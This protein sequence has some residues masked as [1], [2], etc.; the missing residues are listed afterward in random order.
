MQSTDA[1]CTK[2]GQRELLKAPCDGKSDT[3]C[4]SMWSVWSEW[5]TVQ[6][7]SVTPRAVFGAAAACPPLGPDDIDVSRFNV[8]AC[9]LAPY[10]A[11]CYVHCAEGTSDLRESATEGMRIRLCS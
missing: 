1:V 6:R 4:Q 5:A 3:V 11:T 7:L 10:G 9:R 2:C 8:S